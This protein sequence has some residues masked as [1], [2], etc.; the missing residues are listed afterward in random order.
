MD[1]YI[2]SLSEG[3]KA[4]TVFQIS[5]S[6]Y[7][8]GDGKTFEATK[9]TQVPEKIGSHNIL[10]ETNVIN[11]D[12][13]LLLCGASTKRADINLNFKGDTASVFGKTIEL[14]VTKKCH[15]AI[16]LTVPCQ[17]IHSLTPMSM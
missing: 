17:I 4:N 10:I 11:S 14:L 8:F 13:P 6:I 15:Y 7:R 2:D 3:Q 9:K 16:P 5:S 12:I 1:S